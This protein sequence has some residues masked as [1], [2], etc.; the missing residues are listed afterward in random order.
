VYSLEWLSLVLVRTSRELTEKLGESPVSLHRIG[1][2][3]CDGEPGILTSELRVRLQTM[4]KIRRDLAEPILPS[5]AL[6]K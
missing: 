5:Q 6:A 3:V 1:V 4:K 2:G